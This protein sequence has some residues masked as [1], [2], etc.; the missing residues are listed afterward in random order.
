M[1]V[2]NRGQGCLE[3]GE[4]LDAIDLAGLDER[5][6]A[7]PGDAAF[8]VTCKEGILA[9][10]RDGT[11]QVF[12][13][14]AVDFHATVVQEGLQ[15]VPMVMDVG[16]L[17]AEPGFG[18]DLAAL[19]LQP[20]AE[21]GHQR[22]GAGLAGGK[23]LTGRDAADVGLDGIDLGDA[24]Q[25]FGGDLRSVAVED[26]LEFAPR[27]R[28]C[29]DAPMNARDFLSSAPVIDCLHVSGLELRF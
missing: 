24:A 15:P 3:V 19:R 2:G 17:F 6:D 21:V 18:G 9:V 23:A 28:P 25:A 7:A 11:D 13:P 14:V 20:I 16:E 12:D 27:M 5:G 1:S 26:F 10:Q 29:V 8:V 4:G 22:R